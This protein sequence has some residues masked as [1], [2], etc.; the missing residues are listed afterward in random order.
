MST[1]Q[2]N[3]NAFIK[4]DFSLFISVIDD[5]DDEEEDACVTTRSNRA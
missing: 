4:L 2:D 1:A 3:L 5:D